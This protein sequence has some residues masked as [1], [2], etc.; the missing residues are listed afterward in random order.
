MLRRASKI[1]LSAMCGVKIMIVEE[2]R[3]VLELLYV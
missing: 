3:K 2:N 1:G